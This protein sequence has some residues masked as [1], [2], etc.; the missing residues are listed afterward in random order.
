MRPCQQRSRMVKEDLRSDFEHLFSFLH[1]INTAVGYEKRVVFIVFS[2]CD[3]EELVSLLLLCKN[4]SLGLKKC[5]SFMFDVVQRYLMPF[6]PSF[7]RFL[8]CCNE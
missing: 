2:G 5:L 6:P 3:F 8:I 7:F 1:E 4:C